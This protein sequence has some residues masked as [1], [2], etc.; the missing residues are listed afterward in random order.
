[1]EAYF[2]NKSYK[3]CVEVFQV[4][5]TD[6]IKPSKSTVYDIIKRLRET[7]GVNDRKRSGRLRT[8]TPAF[9]E[10]VKEHLLQLIWSVLPLLKVR[11]SGDVTSLLN[12]R[13]RELLIHTVYIVTCLHF[14]G[15]ASWYMSSAAQPSITVAYC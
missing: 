3:K 4:R 2:T 11:R 12:S 1:V 13:V 6:S 14:F 5:F 7:G 8:V 9:V 15:S 10:D